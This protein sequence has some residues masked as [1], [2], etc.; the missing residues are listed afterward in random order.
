MHEIDLG[1]AKLDEL[2]IKTIFG[3]CYGKMSQGGND[4]LKPLHDKL[5]P[6]ISDIDIVGFDHAIKNM[7][8]MRFA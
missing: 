5:R 1:K 7:K 2:D 8:K 3:Y 4:H 6:F